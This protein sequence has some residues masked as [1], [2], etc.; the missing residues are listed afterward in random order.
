MSGEI[1]V[2]RDGVVA[3]VTLHNPAKLNAVNAQMWRQLKAELESLSADDDLRCIVVRGAG[4]HF[5]AGGDIHE[6]ATLRDTLERARVYH[7]RW[8]AGA[9]EAVS[10]CR[11][12]VVAMI[13]GNCIGGGLEI[14][15]A[16]DLRICEESARFGVPI[17]RLGF[18]I[19]HGELR[20]LL[21]IANPSVALELLLEGRIMLADEAYA[22]GLVNRVVTE[23]ALEQEVAATVQRITAGAPLVA[24]LHKHLVRRLATQAPPLSEE[25]IRAN[26]AYLDSED[27]RIGYA[28]FL[29]R[30]K[31]EFVGR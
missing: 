9:L 20:G 8:V 13:R 15:S 21:R 18:A 29:A 30:T 3:T 14:A 24:R 11:H 16:C 31:P 17:N 10:Q 5:A 28:A 2:S 6:F 25:E 12:P 23:D 4:R 22:K 26:F 27:Y 7:D 19:A 1:L